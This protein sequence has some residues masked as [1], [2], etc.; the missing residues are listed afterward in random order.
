[1][2]LSTKQR[3]ELKK[4]LYDNCLSTMF[5]DGMEREYIMDGFPVFKGLNN[6]SDAELIEEAGGFS[7]PEEIET[8]LK[9]Q[10]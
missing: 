8:F 9:E 7:S 3:T 10:S 2:T 6:M 1:M 5:G 4:Y